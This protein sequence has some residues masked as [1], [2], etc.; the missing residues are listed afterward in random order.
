[1][2]AL[3]A[4]RLGLTFDLLY[5]GRFIGLSRLV[6]CHLKDFILYVVLNLGGI[7]A[8]LLESLE[9]QVGVAANDVDLMEPAF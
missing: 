5:N 4:L 8:S 1:M 2:Y 3:Q 7:V 6:E 9:Q